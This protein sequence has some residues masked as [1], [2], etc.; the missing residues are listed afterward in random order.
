MG[1][2]RY[3]SINSYWGKWEKFD[4]TVTIKDAFM[5]PATCCYTEAGDYY[6]DS[7]KAVVGTPQLNTWLG[8][9]PSWAGEFMRID[10]FGFQRSEIQSTLV[11]G[12]ST[13]SLAFC[14]AQG[15]DEVMDCE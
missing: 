15:G 5:R 6:S 8:T 9:Y 12:G 1:S 14:V 11:R 4:S 7:Y 10:V 13:W 3:V 2:V